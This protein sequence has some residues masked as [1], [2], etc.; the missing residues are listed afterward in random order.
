M[1]YNYRRKV[2][3]LE[4]DVSQTA[5]YTLTGFGILDLHSLIYYS[6]RLLDLELYHQKDMT[7]Y[8]NLA[9]S[10]NWSYPEGLIEALAENVDGV[11]TRLR[12]WR[13]SSP[14]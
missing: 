5:A 1:S 10:I 4:M 7:P 12:S 14:I 6:P 13:V 2:E 11:P 9:D 8:R 3:R